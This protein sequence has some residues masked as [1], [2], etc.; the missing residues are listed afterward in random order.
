MLRVFPLVVALTILAS[1]CGSSATATPS[2]AAPTTVSPTASPTSTTAAPATAIAATPVPQTAPPA[3]STPIPTPTPSPSPTRVPNSE[4]LPT[5]RALPTTDGCTA[6]SSTSSHSYQDCIAYGL[7]PGAPV[8]LT[9]NGVNIFLRIGSTV[10]Y[11]DGTWYFP[12]SE[13]ELPKTVAFV[14]SAGGVSRTFRADFY[15]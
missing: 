12:W 15:R 8:T 11:P 10:V 9:A 5:P 2:T 1:A 6:L 13:S 3:V 4:A 7:P 14:V